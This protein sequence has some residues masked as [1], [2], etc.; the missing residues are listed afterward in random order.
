MGEYDETAHQNAVANIKK[1][2][3]SLNTVF[4]RRTY[5][6]GDRFTLADITLASS[7]CPLYQMGIEPR[8]RT[9]FVN[10]NRWF[11]TVCNNPAF[12]KVK[13]CSQSAWCVV[14]Q[15]PKKTKKVEKKPEPKKEAPKDKQ[16]QKPL[17][18]VKR[19]H[20]KKKRR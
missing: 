11:E 3:D 7:L 13:E 20:Q 12:M 16:N 14:A 1:V 15:Q 6:V 17:L 18:K 4:G 19:K 10:L 8:F 9:P 5:L 2:F